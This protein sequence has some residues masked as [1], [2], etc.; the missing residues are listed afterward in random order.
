MHQATAVT[1]NPDSLHQS[2]KLQRQSSYSDDALPPSAAA[3]AAAKLSGGG[4]AF[5]KLSLAGRNE[6]RPLALK[7]ATESL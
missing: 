5:D 4:G 3:A 6:A 2:A 1:A 7:I